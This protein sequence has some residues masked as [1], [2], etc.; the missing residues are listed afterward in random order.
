[1]MFW[2]FGVAVLCFAVT[3]N[4]KL[5]GIVFACSFVV[6]FVVVPVVKKRAA[7]NSKLK[8]PA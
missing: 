4:I 5:A 7:A 3:L 1:M 8:L 6:Y 2:L